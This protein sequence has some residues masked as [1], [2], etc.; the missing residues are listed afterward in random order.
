MK[1]FNN[2]DEFLS[3]KTNKE[4]ANIEVLIGMGSCGIAAGAERVYK[5]FE[6]EIIKQGL[7]SIVLKKV[8]CL[9]LCFA[10][11]NVE[12]KMPD[13]PDVLYGK[14]DE[15]FAT[16]ILHEHIA[17]KNILNENI[18]DKPYIDVYKI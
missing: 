8:G 6:D 7:K 4:E 9:G 10:E 13:M 16:R 17:G 14:V 3:Y 12:I 18:Y 5:V 15:N 2:I 11:P 1:K